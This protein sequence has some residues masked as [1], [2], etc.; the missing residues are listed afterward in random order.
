MKVKVAS[1]DLTNAVAQV[2][3]VTGAKHVS[4]YASTEDETILV[5]GSDKGRTLRLHVPAAVKAEGGVTILPDTLIGVCQRRKEVVLAL[6]D[7]EANVL[8]SSGSYSAKLTVLPYEEV[9]IE[10]PDGIELS[11]ESSELR[12]LMDVCGRAQLTQPYKDGAPPLPL[13]I[14]FSE[15]MTH[16]ASLDTFHV[17]SVKTK[18]I[19][20]DDE[21]EV[22]IPTGT[23]GAVAQAADGDK[24]RLVL[25]DAVVYAN[26]EHFELSLPLEQP[27][28]TD[29]GFSHVKALQEVIRKSEDVT[30]ITVD[31]GELDAILSNIYAV[32]EVGVAI[33][34]EAKKGKLTVSTD[35]T[36]GS[37]SETLT[38]EIKGPAVSCQFNPSLA[39]EIFHKL[40]GDTVQMN[41][42]P[43]FAYLQPRNGETSC[44]YILLRMA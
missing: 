10:E 34:F 40:S 21:Q 1:S 14:H 11:M 13:L 37:A 30:T 32:S 42:L 19:T 38:A 20:R 35:T 3:K 26:N 17:A 28:A 8:V 15:K 44:L 33:T 9:T 23:L 18:Q 2:A 24:Y 5:A 39:A 31:K 4:L 41:I 16:V 43:K 36:Y 29:I 6:D 27:E 22:V 25:S 12:V 7:D